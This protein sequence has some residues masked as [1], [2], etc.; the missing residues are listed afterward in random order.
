MTPDTINS[1]AGMA[2]GIIIGIPIG[3]VI[4]YI[5]FIVKTKI[6][7]NKINALNK[8]TIDQCVDKDLTERI[9]REAREV[10]SR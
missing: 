5:L 2:L 4:L 10:R 9:H 1:Y 8:F 3:L 6:A 7:A